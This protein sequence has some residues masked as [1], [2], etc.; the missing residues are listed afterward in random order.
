MKLHYTLGL[1]AAL[2]GPAQAQP[3]EASAPT[4]R[5]LAIGTIVPGAD[6][7]AVRA[8]LPNEVRETV[9]LYL[10][11]KID[12][13]WSLGDRPG[14]VFLM[15]SNDVKATAELLETLPLGRAH[16]MRFELTPLTP[17]T[18]LRLPFALDAKRP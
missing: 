5:I 9:K 14:V 18:P 4:V 15:N 17:L 10:A 7:A 12:N 8:V 13:W 3:P 6:I 1:L 11:G 16:L 2:S